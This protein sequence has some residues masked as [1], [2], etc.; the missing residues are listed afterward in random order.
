MDFAAYIEEQKKRLSALGQVECREIPYGRQLILEDGI[1][2]VNLNIYNGKKG[3]KTVWGGKDSSLKE[4]AEMLMAD[5][6]EKAGTSGGKRTSSGTG[7]LSG[8]KLK[9]MKNP[10]EGVSENAGDAAGKKRGIYA[11]G[12]GGAAEIVLEDKPGF[13]GIWAGSDESGKGDFFGP[14]VV[15]AVC[16]DKEGAEALINAGVKDCK[17][18]TD[19]KI[20]RLTGII[21]EKAKAFSVLNMKPKAYNMRYREEKA[22]GGNLNT[23][24]ASGHVN[25]LDQVMKKVPECKFAL[26][27]RFMR[28]EFILKEI[29]RRHPG[30]HAFQMPKA[31]RDIAVAAASV[32]ARAAFLETMSELSAEAGEAELPKGGGNLATATAARMAKEAAN[33]AKDKDEVEDVENY[34]SGFV[35]LHFANMKKIDTKSKK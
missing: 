5:V 33:K 16:L 32:L 15:A 29:E 34:L 21:K 20:M 14:L 31:E 7:A 22:H 28:N 9:G 1:N 23:L 13:D 17:A 26:V 12:N 27:D 18:V 3:L 10:G 19:E 30:A 11:Y 35:K 25:A 6:Q 4:Q 2:T 24:L 8:K